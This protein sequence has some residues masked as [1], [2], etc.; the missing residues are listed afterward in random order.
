MSLAAVALLARADLAGNRWRLAAAIVATGV[1]ASVLLGALIGLRAA[2]AGAPLAADLAFAADEAHLIA[3]DPARRVLDE[4]LLAALAA[5]PRVAAVDPC[6]DAGG[7]IMPATESGALDRDAFYGTGPDARWDGWIPGA[8]LRIAAWSGDDRHAALAAGRWPDPAAAGAVE[9]AVP[10]RGLPVRMPL[11]SWWRVESDSG[12]HRAQVVGI[13]ATGPGFAFTPFTRRLPQIQASPAAVERLA[14]RLPEPSHARIRLHDA[15]A[16][17]AFVAE[18]R[19]RC[20]EAAGRPQLWDRG[21][22]ADA[23]DDGWAAASARS[24]VRTAA[25]LAAACVLALAWAVQGASVRERAVQFSLL[26]ALGAGRGAIAL[27]VAAA[28]VPIALGGLAVAVLIAWMA[29]AALF[30]L[31]PFLPLDR[32]PPDPAS[33]L[34]AGLVVLTGALLGAAR[35][36]WTAAHAAAADDDARTA[37]RCLAAAAAVAAATAAAI[38]VTPADGVERAQ[39]LGWIGIPG[40]GLAALLAT[41]ALLRLVARAGAGAVARAVGTEPLVLADHAAGDGARAS[42][43]VVA[44]GVALAAFAALLIW[45]A[46]MLDLFVIDARLPRWMVSVHPYGL[47]RGETERVLAAAPLRQARALVLVDTRL[48]DAAAPWREHGETVPALVLGLDSARELG[49][50]DALPIR[51][52]AGDRAA[53]RAALLDGTGCLVNDWFAASRGLRP[54]DELAVAAPG[55]GDRSYRIAGVVDLRGW[56]MMTKQN[57]VRRNGQA[58]ELLVVLD[59]AAVRRDFPS[60]PWANYLLGDPPDDGADA[61]FRTDLPEPDA[62]AIA[63][64]QRMRLEDGLAALV[65]LDRRLAHRPDGV[66]EVTLS[67]RTV[68]VDDL[69]ATRA[70]LLGDWGGGAVRR[71]GLMPLTALALALFAVAGTL[72]ASLRA[73]S[74]EL[75]ILRACGLTRAGLLRLAL[76]EALLVCLAATAIGFAAGAAAA[77][78]MLEITAILGYRL[79]IGVAPGYVVPWAWLWPGAALA[80]AVCVLAAAWAAWRVGRSSPAALAAG[81]RPS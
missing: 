47:D 58:H 62:R 11:G 10:D 19:E 35:P 52:A 63:H 59:A 48:G 23:V 42:G 61:R 31:M 28:A 25:I 2:R 67:G 7:L 51:F 70:S 32:L 16:R 66:H 60:A 34:I 75:G 18:W 1:A 65:D 17:P 6:R 37:R 78:L 33:I 46:S 38:A 24:A 71:M 26:R 5:D 4:A 55:A 57:K 9:L 54:G 76:G 30:A 45:G 50:G 12:V 56:R 8:D 36:A 64:P 49:D 15:S 14:G 22:I 72:A 39:A 3:C 44:V 79:F 27:S 74:R 77:W 41:P 40:L 53:A 13:I 81:P 43:A 68:Q 29:K 21:T 69:D 73:R 20:A 80:A